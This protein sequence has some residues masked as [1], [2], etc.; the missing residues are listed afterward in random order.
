MFFIVTRNDYFSVHKSD[1]FEK[2]VFDSI[3][4]NWDFTI[5]NDIVN[6]MSQSLWLIGRNNPSIKETE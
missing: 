3:Y 5:L 1:Y 4:A 2:T 6:Y